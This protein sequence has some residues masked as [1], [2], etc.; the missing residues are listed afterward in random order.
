MTSRSLAR[1]G[2]RTGESLI[3][4]NSVGE[5]ATVVNRYCRSVVRCCRTT[6]THH[7]SAARTTIG[8]DRRSTLSA[9]IHFNAEIAQAKLVGI[10]DGNIDGTNFGNVFNGINLIIFERILLIPFVIV[11]Q[12]VGTH[13]HC[14]VI[15]SDFRIGRQTPSA[16]TSG[17]IATIIVIAKTR[18]REIVTV[19]RMRRLRR[20]ILTGQSGTSDT[21]GTTVITLV[22]SLTATGIGFGTGALRLLGNTEL[23]IAV[24]DVIGIGLLTTAGG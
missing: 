16:V 12:T 21:D 20:P 9:D 3:G 8:T 5:K 19:V 22:D 18:I 15:P 7:E 17:G 1:G 23:W 14:T 24:P 4:S 10:D 2:K 13:R 6:G 11:T